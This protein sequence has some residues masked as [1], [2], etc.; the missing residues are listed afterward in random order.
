MQLAVCVLLILQH[1]PFDCVEMHFDA[2]T[3]SMPAACVY[4]QQHNK[5]MRC[6]FHEKATTTAKNTEAA[7]CKTVYQTTTAES[8]K[9]VAKKLY[10]IMIYYR[11]I[12]LYYVWL[13]LEAKDIPPPINSTQQDQEFRN[14][15]FGL[16]KRTLS[17][18]LVLGQVFLSRPLL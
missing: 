13:E 4:Q 5:R 10:Y 18:A 11:K 17:Q 15:G 3:L 6:I 14:A 2:E 16:L 8:K 7:A 12:V 1:N 9:A